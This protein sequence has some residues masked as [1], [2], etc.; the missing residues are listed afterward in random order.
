MKDKVMSELKREFR[1]EFLN[2]VDEIVVF[3]EWSGSMFSIFAIS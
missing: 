1:P 2:R 3:H